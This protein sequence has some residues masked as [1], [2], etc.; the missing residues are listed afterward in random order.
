MKTT[1]TIEQR[2]SQEI[3]IPP[4]FKNGFAHH[5]IIAEGRTVQVSETSIRVDNIV[6]RYDV[7]DMSPCS[8]EE[9]NE[10][11]Q[12]TLRRI[13][14]TNGDIED[15][16]P[17]IW[18]FQ[19]FMCNN[20]EQLKG[21]Q[22]RAANEFLMAI[23]THRESGTGK[24]FLMEHLCEFIEEHGNDFGLEAEREEREVCNG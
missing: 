19:R 14:A 16:K 15:I 8:E 4:F 7:T 20:G 1:I 21:W 2:V 5:K 3:E 18:T 22:E 23:H 9:F 13:I 24:S 11:Y 6:D 17:H 10:A 12:K